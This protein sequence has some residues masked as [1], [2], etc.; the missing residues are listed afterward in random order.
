MNIMNAEQK[1]FAYLVVRPFPETQDTD[2]RNK[3]RN[4]RKDVVVGGIELEAQCING[5]E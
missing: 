3:L 1:K 5:E 4:T 2:H